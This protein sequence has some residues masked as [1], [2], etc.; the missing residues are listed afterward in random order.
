RHACLPAEAALHA[1]LAGHARYLLGEGGQRVGH[2]VDGLR[3]RG[4]LALRFEGQLAPQVAVG[5]RGHDARDASHLVGEVAGHRVDVV[6]EVLPDPTD[7]LDLG[8]AAELAVGAHLAGDT[9]D[10]GRECVELVDHRVDG[11]FLV[12][13][14]TER[15]D[16]DL[17]GEVDRRYLRHALADAAHLVG[18]VAGHRVD[19]VGEVLPDAADAFDMGLAAE[20]ALGSHLVRDAGDLGREGVELIDHRV[21]GVLQ[22]EDLALNVDGDLLGEVAVGDG[23]RYFGDVADL[24]R[25]I[26]GH[27]VDVFGEV[28]L[29]AADALH[30]V[31]VAELVLCS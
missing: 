4:D 19:V 6:G 15:I 7:A 20:L 31:M 21:D 2:A 30:L 29:R 9:R 22:F 8:L 10:L 16:G 14:L 23:G 12:Q 3:Q 27:R 17:L 28:L 18:Q 1:H 5:Y 11:V 26:A 13:E 25:Q 24:A